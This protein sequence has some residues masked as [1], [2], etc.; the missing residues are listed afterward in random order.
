MSKSAS[1]DRSL[2]M[3][4]L[5]VGGEYPKGNM[6]WQQMGIAAYLVSDYM[7]KTMGTRTSR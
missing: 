6:L 7:H 3:F 4:R 1:N 2:A 5:M